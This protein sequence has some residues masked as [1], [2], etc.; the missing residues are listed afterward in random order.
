MNSLLVQVAWAEFH[1]TPRSL[2]VDS[3]GLAGAATMTAKRQ[4]RREKKAVVRL[5]H[6]MTGLVVPGEAS[7]TIHLPAP[8]VTRH[9]TIYNLGTRKLSFGRFLSGGVADKLTGYPCQGRVAQCQCL[10]RRHAGMLDSSRQDE[11]TS[12]RP[13]EYLPDLTGCQC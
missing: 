1:T 4:A 9:P 12:T 8:P 13:D 2:A 6:S 10:A 7:T 3:S 11:T 5:P